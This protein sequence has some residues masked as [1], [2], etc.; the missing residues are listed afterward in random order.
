LGLAF[1]PSRVRSNEGL[2]RIASTFDSA[3]ERVA[4]TRGRERV[5]WD[6]YRRV[7]SY[8]YGRHS[9]GVDDLVNARPEKKAS[10]VCRF[11]IQAF[12]LD[13]HSMSRKHILVVSRAYECRIQRELNSK[14]RDI[15]QHERYD[16]QRDA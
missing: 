11:F 12:F 5:V 9:G 10:T 8:V 3:K 1:Y 14:Q 13:L 15:N 4:I 16:R 6:Q 7:C 2:D